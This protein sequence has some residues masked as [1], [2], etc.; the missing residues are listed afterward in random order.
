[1]GKDRPE[2][3][4]RIPMQRRPAMRAVLG[5]VITIR[6]PHVKRSSTEG[7]VSERKKVLREGPN[8]SVAKPLGMTKAQDLVHRG[9]GERGG[10]AA[11]SSA[12]PIKKEFAL[13]A[14]WSSPRS[15]SFRSTN[16]A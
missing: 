3:C 2:F 12:A 10:R 15:A 9:G 16:S 6:N 1:M 4:F 8:R 14:A 7:S 11:A 13:A 5:L